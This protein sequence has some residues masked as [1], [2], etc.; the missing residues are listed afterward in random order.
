[1]TPPAGLSE[2]PRRTDHHRQRP[3]PAPTHHHTARLSPQANVDV[4]GEIVPIPKARI[5]AEVHVVGADVERMV[6]ASVANHTSMARG[7]ESIGRE[8]ESPSKAGP[9]TGGGAIELSE[10]TPAVAA[11]EEDASPSDTL[12]VDVDVVDD[13][14]KEEDAAGGS[15]HSG[16]EEDESSE[17]GEGSGGSDDEG[18]GGSYDSDEEGSGSYSGSGSYYSGSGSD[19]GSGSEG[20]D[21]DGEYSDEEEGSD[22]GK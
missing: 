9:A 6:S 11:G 20:E 17:D 4:E 7:L 22:D 10:V 8:G 19:E 3:E 21:D 18:S 12:D 14:E 15:E 16:S 13:E 2:P 1:M 5:K